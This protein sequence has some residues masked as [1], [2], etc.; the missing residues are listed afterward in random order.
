MAI[1]RIKFHNY[2]NTVVTYASPI[3]ESHTKLFVKVYRNFWLG[4]IGDYAFRSWMRTTMEEDKEI[5]EEIDPDFDGF[6][7]RY[8][9]LQNTYRTYY[10]KFYKDI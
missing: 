4:Y 8:D 1:A 5:V 7:M 3:N 10:R 9:K 6:N 2:T